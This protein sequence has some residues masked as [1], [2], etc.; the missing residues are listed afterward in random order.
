M[1]QTTK[2]YWLQLQVLG[3]CIAIAALHVLFS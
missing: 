2:C 1:S 3:G